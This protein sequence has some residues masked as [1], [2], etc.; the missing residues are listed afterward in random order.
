MEANA[1]GTVQEAH[2]GAVRWGKPHSRAAHHPCC[3]GILAGIPIQALTALSRRLLM[4]LLLLSS[5]HVLP[6]SYKEECLAARSH[7]G[8]LSKTSS[9]WTRTN[10]APC[11]GLKG[12]KMIH[13]H[14]LHG[15]EQA[16]P[17]FS[18]SS[19]ITS[20]DCTAPTCAQTKCLLAFRKHGKLK[21]AALREDYRN[22]GEGS[23]R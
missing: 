11:T 2:H 9:Q 15:E 5:G 7:Q 22:D 21:K 1:T 3:S 23:V 16:D 6:G 20:R 17:T 14:Y 10:A 4:V 18:I 8:A 12:C 13:K 19:N